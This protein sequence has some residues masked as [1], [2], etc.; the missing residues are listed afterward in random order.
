MMIN[1]S[2][3]AVDLRRFVLAVVVTRF[4]GWWAA[5]RRSHFI[6]Y[7]AG[8]NAEKGRLNTDECVVGV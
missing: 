6:I 4:S 5:G 3:V 7:G 2:V 1:Q 8:G